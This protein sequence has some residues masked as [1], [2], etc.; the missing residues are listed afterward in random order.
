MRGW[1]LGLGLALVACGGGERDDTFRAYLSL[2]DHMVPA[3]N[4]QQIEEIRAFLRRESKSDDVVVSHFVGAVLFEGLDLPPGSEVVSSL[5]IWREK[6]YPHDAV[7]ITAVQTL[8]DGSRTEGRVR[9]EL[10]RGEGQDWT[11]FRLPLAGEV[12]T[13]TFYLQ[14]AA[15]TGEAIKGRLKACLLRPHVRYERPR[16]PLPPERRQVFFLTLDTLRRDHLGCY[17]AT[18]V[19]T[20]NLDAFARDAHLFEDAFSTA[21]VTNPSHVSM[22]TSLYLKDHGVLNNF[23]RLD[24]DCPN[25][26]EGFGAAG[27]RTAGFVGSFNFQPER[28]DLPERFEEFF[29]CGE[30]FERRAEDVHDDLFEWLGQHYDEDLFVWAHYFD[31]HM[32]Y[33][34]PYPYNGWYTDTGDEKIQLPNRDDES[35]E[36]YAASDDLAYYKNM[37]RGEI[38]YLDAQ[39]GELMDLLRDLGIYDSSLIV[40]VADHGEHL[41][42]N[43][44]YCEHRGLYDHTTAVPLMIKFPGRLYAGRS[45]GLVSTVDIYPTIFETLGLD[46]PGPVRGR[47]LLGL[48]SGR[49]TEA[50]DRVF[51]EHT[52]AYQVS[53]RTAQRRALLGLHDKEVFPGFA[54]VDGKLELYDAASAMEAEDDLAPELSE[55]A[56]FFAEELRAFRAERI[57]YESVGIND[58]EYIEKM[59]ALGYVDLPEEGAGD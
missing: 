21:N 51:S 17:G 44:I 38:S 12:A 16:R 9:V 39:L 22:F 55:E 24:P 57:A 2:W 49:T 20:P 58:P 50:R 7:D 45:E 19:R 33:V 25:M 56:A 53:V 14:F 4:T 35:L 32:P 42:E 27:F 28:S 29:G 3:S 15:P 37:Y 31:A 10:G 1:I 43:G 54:I 23:A 34:P 47:S 8:A 18:D 36:M 41:G 46:V 5:R 52:S 40:V 59:R 26:I 30:H 11:P 48:A 13:T 6:R